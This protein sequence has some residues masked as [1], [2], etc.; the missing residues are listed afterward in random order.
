[1]RRLSSETTNL[2]LHGCAIEPG[3]GEDRVEIRRA[4]A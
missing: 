2:G 1:M 4:A 3:K